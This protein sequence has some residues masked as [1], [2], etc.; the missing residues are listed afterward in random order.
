MTDANEKID[1]IRLHGAALIEAS[2]GTGKT[3]TIQNLYLRMIAGWRDP[4]NGQERELMP[5]SVLVMTYTIPAT[6]ELKDRIR[7]ILTLAQQ[8]LDSPG[9]LNEDDR[10]R[11]D[12]LLAEPLSVFGVESVRWRLRNALLSFDDAAIYTI[13]GFCQRMLTQ[14]AFESGV[15]FNA[16]IRTDVDTVIAGIRDDYIRSFCYSESDLLH[17]ELKRGVIGALTGSKL[18]SMVNEMLSRDRVKIVGKAELKAETILTELEQIIPDLRSSY[19]PGL[20]AS[21]P[22]ADRKEAERR[23]R[24]LTR[25]KEIETIGQTSR[26]VFEALSV[27][28]EW[29]IPDEAFAGLLEKFRRLNLN[30]R[31]ALLEHAAEWIIERLNQRKQQENFQTFDDLLKHVRAAVRDGS[32]PLLQVIR[33]QYQAAIVDEFQDTDPIQ[34][35]IFRTV[36]G[37]PAAGHLMFFFFVPKQAIYGFRGGDIT[38]YQAAKDFVLKREGA[39]YSLGKNFRSSPKLLNSINDLFAKC[40]RGVSGPES[41]FA[42]PDIVFTPVSAGKSGPGLLDKNGEEDPRPFKFCRIEPDF[43]TDDSERDF[44]RDKML[45]CAFRACA[46]DIVALLSSG[47]RIPGRSEPLEPCDIAVLVADKFDARQ[48]RSELLKRN[49]PCVIPKSENVFKTPAAEYLAVLLRAVDNPSDPNLASEAMLTPLLGYT[50]DDMVAIHASVAGAGSGDRLIA[51]QEKLTTLS[52][53]WHQVSFLKM[54]QEMLLTFGIRSTLLA[55]QEG[56]RILTD[57]LQLRDLI[58]QKIMETGLSSSS[59]LNYLAMQAENADSEEKETMMETDRAAVVISTLHGSKGLEYP[60][61]MLPAVWKRVWNRTDRDI[62]YHDSRKNLVLNLSPDPDAVRL[63]ELQKKQEEMRLLYVAL[64]RAQYSCFLY[65]G[66]F[67]DSSGIVTTSAL[68]W[69]FPEDS[70]HYCRNLT[71][72]VAQLEK[73]DVRLIHPEQIACTRWIPNKTAGKPLICPEWKGRI[74]SGYQFVSFSMLTG[75]H[76]GPDADD[77]DFDDSPDLLERPTGIFKIPPG[78]QTGNAWHKVLEDIDFTTFGSDPEAEMRL[79]EDK[80]R[81]FGVL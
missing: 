27:P 68:D 22:D 14:Y 51:V 62:C 13:H 32:G 29:I 63:I 10:K 38:V 34:Y 71:E 61:A 39:L 33:K 9:L 41:V 42:D 11:L 65:W 44:R 55:R 15:M 25:W 30:Y 31:N 73:C 56:E 24:I 67:R 37:D 47:R 45:D 36:F 72:P 64:T 28:D 48:M 70:G 58:H 54:F 3:Y 16:R 6:E 77:Y 50:V 7:K 20:F 26:E 79:I 43:R 60:V 19:R 18:T 57:L 78:A 35:E 40:P 52:R 66:L 8:Y 4:E 21:V 80:M 12:G 1:D 59:V 23:D 76:S 81:M 17:T 2:A 75:G 53:L 49:I 74:D 69:L 46:E 5:E